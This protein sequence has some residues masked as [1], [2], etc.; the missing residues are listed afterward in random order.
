MCIDEL[1]SCEYQEVFLEVNF[2]ISLF[3]PKRRKKKKKTR[4]TTITTTETATPPK[5]TPLD[6]VCVLACL[7]KESKFQNKKEN[8]ST[9]KVNKNK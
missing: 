7:L 3:Y 4:K 2:S 9:M 6:P 5:K 1:P 8:Q